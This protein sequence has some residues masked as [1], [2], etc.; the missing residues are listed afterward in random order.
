MSCVFVVK[1]RTF[2]R[3][4]PQS[5]LAPAAF[6]LTF[7]PSSPTYASLSTYAFNF[8]PRLPGMPQHQDDVIQPLANQSFSGS[9]CATAGGCSNMRQWIYQSC[10]EFGFFQTTTG[11]AQP[12]AAFSS[13][14]VQNAGAAICKAGTSYVSSDSPCRSLRSHSLSS[15]PFPPLHFPPLSVPSCPTPSL[16]LPVPSLLVPSL[17]SS[18]LP[19]P[20]GPIPSLPFPSLF[21]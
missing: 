15:C 1:R 21:F 9:G 5:R 8:S 6:L 7:A 3:W 16:Q 20:S 18:P 17:P 14:T 2:C 12:F 11:K 13:L 19:T 4:S 10:M